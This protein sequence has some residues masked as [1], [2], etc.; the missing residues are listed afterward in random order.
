ISNTLT[1]GV[2]TSITVKLLSSAVYDPK[3]VNIS[4]TSCNASTINTPGPPP[5]LNILT[6]GMRAWATT[7]HLNTSGSPAVGY[8]KTETPFST[9]EL[10]VSELA[11][12]TSFCG[13]IQ[14]N[15][16]GFGICKSCRF[17][18]LGGEQK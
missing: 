6:R 4:A 14:A 10:S 2:P 11:K 3:G 9:A 17:G 7:L 12:L 8:Q 5:T 18:A 1:P 13:F 16:S 15:G